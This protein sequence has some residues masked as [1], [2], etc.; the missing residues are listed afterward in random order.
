MLEKIDKIEDIKINK[1]VINVGNKSL[2]CFDKYPKI[3]PIRGRKI[4]AYSI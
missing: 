4:V 2:T 1:V 3:D